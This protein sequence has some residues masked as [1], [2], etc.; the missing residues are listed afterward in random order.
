MNNAPL[1]QGRQIVLRAPIE[2]DIE[3]RMLL[4]MTKE[5]AEMIGSEF[6]KIQ[7]FTHD[8]ALTWYLRASKHPCKW[9]VEHLGKC[10]GTVGLRLIEEDNK[11]KFAIELYDQSLYGKGIGTEV[12]QLVLRYAFQEK[13]YHKVFLR[14]LDYN[15]RGIALYKKCGFTIDGI[16]RE[17][18]KIQGEYHSDIY[19]GILKS[20]YEEIY[21]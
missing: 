17:G 15:H 7:E 10:I 4:G 16:D 18:A 5:C 14:V 12:T 2:K 19:M 8:H 11:A 3:D 13:K 1:I 9:V 21:K 6:D 20:E